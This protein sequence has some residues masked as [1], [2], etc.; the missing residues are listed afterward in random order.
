M[1]LD[2]VFNGFLNVAQNCKSWNERE[3]FF[4]DFF[5]FFQGWGLSA[6]SRAPNEVATN[7]SLTGYFEDPLP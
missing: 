6:E 3:E 1:F 7:P 4:V 5:G 2:F